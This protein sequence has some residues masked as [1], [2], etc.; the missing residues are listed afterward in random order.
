MSFFEEQ[1]EK[2]GDS[3]FCH[4]VEECEDE[5]EAFDSDLETDDDDST[6]IPARFHYNPS[7][8]AYLQ[9]LPTQYSAMTNKTKWKRHGKYSS[10]K[11]MDTKNKNST[12]VK[13][14]HCCLGG[15][16]SKTN[17]HHNNFN[18]FDCGINV[19]QPGRGIVCDCG[20]FTCYQC[21]RKIEIMVTEDQVLS[22]TVPEYLNQMFQGMKEGQRTI[23]KCHACFL[24]VN[25]RTPTFWEKVGHCGIR[26][27][28]SKYD[29]CL[30]FKEFGLL[31]DS[32]TI[33]I[34]GRNSVDVH[35]L[36]QEEGSGAPFHCVISPKISKQ[37]SQGKGILN[38][39]PILECCKA[40]TCHP[41]FKDRCSRQFLRGIDIEHFLPDFTP[42]K[43]KRK[44]HIEIITVN[45]LR[46]QNGVAYSE[47]KDPA[48]L[49][50][51]GDNDVSCDEINN[52]VILD[53][54]HYR[55][56]QG[57]NT[58][59]D[60]TFVLRKFSGREIKSLLVARFYRQYSKSPSP[61][62]VHTLFNSV[63]KIT[64]NDAV[65]RTRFGGAMGIFND[66]PQSML[67]CLSNQSLAPRK[68]YGTIIVPSKTS[69]QVIY[70]SAEGLPK[71]WK[72]S[73]PKYGGQ[74]KME[75]FTPGFFHQFES[76]YSPFVEC[77]IWTA[78]L[79]NSVNK[80]STVV[81]RAVETELNNIDKTLIESEDS[82]R[83]TA[84]A[85]DNLHQ[86]KFEVLFR[87]SLKNRWSIN[88]YP[89]AQHKDY[90]KSKRSQFSGLE[91]KI[92]LSSKNLYC[93]FGHGRGG[94][95]D[96][97]QNDGTRV[98]HRSNRFV[99][100]LLDWASGQRTVDGDRVSCRDIMLQYN[101]NAPLRIRQEVWLA[102]VL[103]NA[104][105]L[106]GDR[107][108]QHLLRDGPTQLQLALARDEG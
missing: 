67:E 68:R 26:A 106:L 78:H 40:S 48:L 49:I 99:F 16:Q 57:K 94:K 87:Y 30:L 90:F 58:K 84:G 93:V 74:L 97:I 92:C 83:N 4:E 63:M 34:E 24:K 2:D 15:Y 18:T 33:D 44:W 25:G 21:L 37:L 70:I 50:E 85:W 20:T 13:S 75:K 100:C 6:A 27:P 69:F 81:P 32:N 29:G 51:K 82:F 73:V 71:K 8:P 72:Y 60:V 36:G 12:I 79:L 9:L 56:Y 80:L 64:N 1:K 45:E 3:F 59:L 31:V 46:D 53:E 47:S 66:N 39:T 65:E 86:F 104:N 105:R 14:R 43:K 55:G 54:H 10:Q 11:K 19:G 5:E 35:G 103:T 41:K 38:A 28:T 102:F 101:G 52:S 7:R 77:K 76:I 23:E 61:D 108:A 22:L 91:N 95:G 98:R 107:R 96:D 17:S 88:C 42:D 89:A 62:Q